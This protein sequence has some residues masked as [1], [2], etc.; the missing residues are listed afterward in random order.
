MVPDKNLQPPEAA[1]RELRRSSI[2]HVDMDAFFVSVELRSRPE[3]VGKPVIV[4][5]PADRSVVL[6]ASYEAR[7]FGV[8]PAMPMVVAQRMCPR[9]VIIEPRHKLYY[10]V[11]AELMGIFESITQLV[12]PLSVDE[13]LPDGTPY[14][15]KGLIDAQ[16]LHK[17]GDGFED[18]HQLC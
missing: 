5:H 11:S 2:M 6:S 12:E 17:L 4:G 13:A 3:L 10:E 14:I 18:P 7:S 15:Q 8:K 16:R 1:L 9:A